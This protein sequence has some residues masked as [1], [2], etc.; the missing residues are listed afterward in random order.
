MNDSSCP[1]KRV[2]A[3]IKAVVIACFDPNRA[4]VIASFDP[5]LQV[6]VYSTCSVHREE[7]E[8]VV[9]GALGEFGHDF[10]LEQCMPGWPH[11]GALLELDAGPVRCCRQ[12]LCQRSIS[13]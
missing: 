3:L 9:Q 8:D 4:V 12:P 13:R 5:T 10:E 1:W 2:Q 11:R 7:N 6:V